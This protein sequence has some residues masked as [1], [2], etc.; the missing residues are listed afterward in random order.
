MSMRSKLPDVGTTIFSVISRR[1]IEFD[2]M[3]VGQGFP[4]FPID[5]LLAQCVTEAM[6]Q[7]QNQYA[8]GDGVPELREAIAAKLADAHGIMVD[9]RASI[10][11]TCGATE[12]LFSTIQAMVHPGDEVLVFDPAYDSYE[13]AVRLAGG[14]CIRIPLLPPSFAFDFD[15]VRAALT[16]RTRLVIVNTPHN[17]ACVA[18]DRSVLDTLAEVLRGRDI[19]ILSDEVYEHTVF[20]GRAHTSVLAHPELRERTFAVFSFGKTLHVTGWRVGYCV[21]TPP[22][23]AEFRKVHQFNTFSIATPLQR[24]IARYLKQRPASWSELAGFFQRKR[25]LLTTLLEGSGFRPLPTQG[26]YFQ[27]L[28]Y[29]ELTDQDDVGFSDRLIREAG[30]ALIPLSPFYRERPDTRLLRI[31]FAKRDE[32]LEAAA[33]RL[34]EFALRS[35]ASA[36]A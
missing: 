13:P 18:H 33:Q 4:D 30:V 35:A 10:T 20:D 25:D 28:D 24:G 17:P 8:Q 19:W 27:L 31:C 34:R 2:A 7:G 3:N 23:M 36:L 15:R 32:T 11:V 9:P 29:S 12:A 6:A 5:P 1:A 21:A 16:E 26:T 22:L 14:R